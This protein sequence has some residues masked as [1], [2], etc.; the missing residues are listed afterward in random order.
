MGSARIDG[1]N[2]G[3][4]RVEMLLEEIKKGGE[5]AVMNVCFGVTVIIC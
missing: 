1:R 5:N 3:I 4:D 2:Y